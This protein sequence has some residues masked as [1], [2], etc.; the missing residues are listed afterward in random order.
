[1][2]DHLTDIAERCTQANLEFEIRRDPEGTPTGVSIRI[3]EAR[4]YRI[5][6]IPGEGVA[7]QV[8]PSRF[9]HYKFISGYEAIW[10]SGDGVLECELTIGGFVSPM[11]AVQLL[12]RLFNGEAENAEGV[13]NENRD[14]LDLG[15][16]EPGVRVSIGRG[17]LEHSVL[18][19]L[20]RGGFAMPRIRPRSTI[21]FEGTQV[22][23]HD[24]ALQLLDRLGNAVLFKLDLVT[25][26]P[27]HLR[28][29]RVRVRTRHRRVETVQWSPPRYSYDPEPM[30][31]YWYARDSSEMPL[32][33]FLAFYQVLEFYFPVYSHRHAQAT[34]R[35]LLRDP[36]FDVERDA[37]LARILDA[38]KVTAG[39]RSFGEEK[40]QFKAT[41]QACIT[42]SELR[43]FIREDEERSDF[44]SQRRTGGL[45]DIN[46]PL[47][48]EDQ[49]LTP[50]IASRLYQ[51]R[52]RIVHTKNEERDFEL[53]L[54]FSPEVRL[55]RHDLEIME[56]L[57]QK[58]IVANCRPLVI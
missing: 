16:V 3:P 36:R 55:I 48:D 41:V 7:E 45:S 1:M 25:A 37:D 54:P 30:S 2:P 33:Q 12:S 21:K 13:E 51:I 17:S 53:V 5:V 28:T 49:D 24:Q 29:E 18:T 27:F 46:V 47:G 22:T 10:S 44:Y 34:I 56:F 58:V 15:T 35:N 39:G 43:D 40:T 23:T 52:C 50:H 26:H 9:E 14:R 6:V 42:N 4:G 20:Q 8:A 32:L 57:A 31:L 11:L 38:V 19:G